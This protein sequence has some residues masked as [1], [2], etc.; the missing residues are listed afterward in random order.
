VLADHHQIGVEARHARQ[1]TL[2]GVGR[3]PRLAVGD[4]HNLGVDARFA[5]ASD[6]LQH[7]SCRHLGRLLADRVEEQLQV[8]RR[9][10]HG[11]RP[12]SGGHE[13][14]VPVKLWMARVGGF[15]VPVRA[16]NAMVL[17]SQ[18]PSV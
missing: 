18:R 5:L 11:V 13:L 17:S 4:T 14:Q 16:V 1:P 7:V 2:D 12:T 3:Q 15:S 10:Q 8:R 9:R 6:E